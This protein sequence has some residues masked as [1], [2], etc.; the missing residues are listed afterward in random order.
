M[1]KYK[2]EPIL[3]E[4]TV[5]NF[6]KEILKPKDEIMDILKQNKKM[7]FAEVDKKNYNSSRHFHICKNVIKSKVREHTGKYIG[8]AYYGCNINRNHKNFKIPVS[9]HNGKG[10]DSHFIIMKLLTFKKLKKLILFQ[11][12]KKN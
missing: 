10:Y 3:G 4:N 2:F 7:I 1:K 9:F 12:P 11:K 5:H 8:A 6:L